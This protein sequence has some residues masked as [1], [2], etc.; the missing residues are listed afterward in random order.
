MAEISSP[1]EGSARGPAPPRAWIT[2]IE[3]NDGTRI[4]IARHEILVVVGPNNAG[5]SAALRDIL[6][7]IQNT[8]N[9]YLVVAKVTVELEG[10]LFRVG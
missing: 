4:D 1:N 10:D 9:N 7:K 5:K 6:N 8:D 3:F 2:S